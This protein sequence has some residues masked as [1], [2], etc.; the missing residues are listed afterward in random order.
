LVVY[1]HSHHEF[2]DLIY[3]HVYRRLSFV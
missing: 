2:V 3:L 1:V